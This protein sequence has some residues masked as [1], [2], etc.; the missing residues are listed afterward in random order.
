[1]PSMAKTF[2]I[3]DAL[4]TSNKNAPKDEYFGKPI[5][6]TPRFRRLNLFFNRFVSLVEEGDY[7]EEAEADLRRILCNVDVPQ[8]TE[9]VLFNGVIIDGEEKMKGRVTFA[10]AWIPMPQGW[11]TPDPWLE[12]EAPDGEK[13]EI[14]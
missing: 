6:S 7:R 4:A 12:E 9:W 14:Q 13:M 1:M 2:Y 3:V 10:R 11:G 8:G 5:K